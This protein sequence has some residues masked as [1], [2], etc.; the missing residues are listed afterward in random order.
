MDDSLDLFSSAFTFHTA[1]FVE[2]H[3]IHSFPC[4]LFTIDESCYKRWRSLRDRFGREKKK[5]EES[6]RR[7]E[8]HRVIN[9]PAGPG[10]K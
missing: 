1:T 6:Q 7:Y 8:N 5:L 3:A 10:W 9:N 2:Y 4:L